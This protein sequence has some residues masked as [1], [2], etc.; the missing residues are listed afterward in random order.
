VKKSFVTIHPILENKSIYQY[1][2]LIIIILIAAGLR[3]YKLDEWSFWGDE[4]FTISG[5]EDGFNYTFARQSLSSLLIQITVSLLGTS[6]WN[7]RLVPVLIGI[8]SIPILYFPIRK[9]FSPAVGLMAV[10]LLAISP[11]HLYW[12]Q[13]ARF[14][15]ALLLF[16]TLALIFFYFGLEEDRPDYLLISLIFLG[17]ATKERLLALF[18]APVV[19]SH[20]VLLK[21]LPFEKPAGLRWRNLAIFILPGLVLALFFVGPYLKDL[22]GWLAGF[23][24]ASNHPFWL[25]ASVTYYVGIPTLAMSVGGA[26]YLLTKKSRAALLLSLGAVIPL[27]IMI[28]I[29][30]FHYTASRYLFISL[31]SWIILAGFA[32]IELFFQSQKQAKILALAGVLILLLQP[33][34]ENILYYSYQHGNRDNWKAAFELIK[35]HREAG[36]LIVTTNPEL[37]NY[38]LQ[39]K[40][41]S[42]RK[43]DLAQIE[44]NKGNIWFVEDGVA[45]E[46]YPEIHNWLKSNA[47]LVANFDVH[48]Q[49]KNFVMRVYLHDSVKNLESSY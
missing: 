45:H 47:R 49:A 33:L 44:A 25:L 30:P 23:G 1:L 7:A 29:S 9:M 48:A 20:V 21:V 26:L 8:I 41:V 4:M 35:E 39:D 27:L 36:D 15:I 17:L 28:S 12:S 16:Y 6:E 32:A 2:L 42:W 46:R 11:W 43:L 3:F 37:G 5:R 10:V 22:S 38:Y 14:Y 18:F 31:T 24:Y 19:A 34:G 13:N 40:I